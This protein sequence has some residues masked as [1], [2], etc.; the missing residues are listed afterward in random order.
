MNINLDKTIDLIETPIIFINSEYDIKY[1]NNAA[2]KI[3]FDNNSILNI[4]D[5]V[6]LPILENGIKNNFPFALSEKRLLKK[7]ILTTTQDSYKLTVKPI[8]E[9]LYLVEFTKTASV[10]KTSSLLIKKNREFIKHSNILSDLMRIKSNGSKIDTMTSEEIIKVY[11]EQ[12]KLQFA[13]DDAVNK[14]IAPIV[15]GNL[16]IPDAAELILSEIK[17]IVN[18]QKGFIIAKSESGYDIIH[19]YGTNEHLSDSKKL[20]MLFTNLSNYKKPAY[21]NDC[22]DVINCRDFAL[23]IDVFHSILIVPLVVEGIDYGYIVLIDSPD[24]FTETHLKITTRLGQLFSLSIQ[25]TNYLKRLRNQ[26]SIDILTGCYNRRHGMSMLDTIYAKSKASKKPFSILFFDINNLKTVNDKMGH[27]Y[28]DD[29]I[30]SF[31]EITRQA[32]REDEVFSRYGGDEFVLILPDCPLNIAKEIE[33]RILGGIDKFNK[34][35]GKKFEVNVS[36]GAIE[37]NSE[38]NMTTDELI[39]KADEI[40]YE[41]KRKYK[42]ELL[43]NAKNNPH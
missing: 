23:S 39:K 21:F 6:Y 24:V 38:C 4:I 14:T 3:I 42:Q 40:M 1:F 31:A 36:I 30:R 9:S 10:K 12:L 2:K 34:T 15:D 19:E 32:I 22:H 7:S 41:N 5:E 13:I 27:D 33:G 25:R 37:Y 16:T 11:E 26:A 43:K 17:N 29:L 28:G 8:D 20:S 35:A 18:S